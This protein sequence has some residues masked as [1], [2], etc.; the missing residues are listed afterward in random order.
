[1]FIV[2]KAVFVKIKFHFESFL[3]LH[4]SFLCCTVHFIF[5]VHYDN[6]KEGEKIT[7][8]VTLCTFKAKYGTQFTRKIVTKIVW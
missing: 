3:L 7:F 6:V 8:S 4:F 5:Q 2:S 1:L